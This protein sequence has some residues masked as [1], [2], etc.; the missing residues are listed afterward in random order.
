MSGGNIGFGRRPHGVTLTLPISP[1]SEP[2]AM[3]R[4][5][6]MSMN[7]VILAIARLIPDEF[8]ANA[9]KTKKK[10]AVVKTVTLKDRRHYGL[11]FIIH[12]ADNEQY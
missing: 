6:A 3:T 9:P 7:E 4:L 2:M 11:H 10:A 1:M 5:K 8:S 12:T